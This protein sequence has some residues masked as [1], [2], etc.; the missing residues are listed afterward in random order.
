ME[1]CNSVFPVCCPEFRF[2]TDVDQPPLGVKHAVCGPRMLE[3]KMRERARV[4]A[5]RRGRL[6]MAAIGPIG[7]YM[8]G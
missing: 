7:Q 1:Y 5:P 3:K 2:F 4:I 8:N 6:H